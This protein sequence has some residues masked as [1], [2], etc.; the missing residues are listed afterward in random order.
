[1]T[2]QNGEVQSK[3]RD[4][5]LKK[6]NAEWSRSVA[7]K[8]RKYGLNT[9]AK[10]D[11]AEQAVILQL[12]KNGWGV[13]KPIGDRLSYDLIVD[14]EGKLCKI[15]VKSAWFRKSSSNF[16]CETRRTKTNRRVMLRSTY[17]STDFDFAVVYASEPNLFW[18]LPVKDFISWKGEISF[19]L[20]SNKQR[21]LRSEDFKNAWNLILTWASPEETLVM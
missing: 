12:L 17:N 13:A 11:I 14:V 5:N 4:A 16:H 6:H 21:R 19:A 20:E 18:V 2:N 1:M 8:A 3:S 7:R 15:Q 9:K 10:G